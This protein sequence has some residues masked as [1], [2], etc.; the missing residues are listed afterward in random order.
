[1]S[2]N[3]I[4]ATVTFWTTVYLLRRQDVVMECET[5]ILVAAGLSLFT[6]VVASCVIKLAL[7]WLGALLFG[8]AALSLLDQVPELTRVLGDQTLADRAWFHWGAAAVVG[9]WAAS[10]FGIENVAPWRFSHLSSEGFLG[11][12]AS[13]PFPSL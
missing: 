12:R 1:M 2:I 5:R 3:L 11:R 13:R 4:A 8:G 6:M 7:Y 10:C 9:L